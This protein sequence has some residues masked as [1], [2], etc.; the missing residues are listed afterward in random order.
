M[1]DRFPGRSLFALL[2]AIILLTPGCTRNS[3]GLFGERID[4]IKVDEPADSPPT[5][6]IQ[7]PYPTQVPLKCQDRH[8]RPLPAGIFLSVR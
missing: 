7:G 5:V 1:V 6:M 2:T 4:P 3:I 8:R